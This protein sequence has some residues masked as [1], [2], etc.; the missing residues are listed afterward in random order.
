MG[1]LIGLVAVFA[2]FS[3]FG[4]ADFMSAGGAASWLNVASE[5]GI[6]A[7]PIG[8]LMIAGHLDL[9]G[10]QVHHRRGQH[11]HAEEA[12][13]VAGAQ[14]GD[15]QALLGFGGGRLLHY[16]GDFVKALA[17]GDEMAAYGAVEGE[18]A[19]MRG[20]DGGDGA[21]LGSG[22]FHQLLRGALLRAADVEMIAD[23]QEE[24]SG[25]GKGAGAKDR[26]AIAAGGGLLDELQ[27]A[28]LGAGGGPIGRL[29]PGTD[30][31]ANL[32]DTGGDDLVD[33]NL[34]GGLGK[35][36]AVDEGLKGK[37]ALGLASRSDDGSFDL[38]GFKGFRCSELRA[39]AGRIPVHSQSRCA[40]RHARWAA[41]RPLDGASGA[42]PEAA[43]Q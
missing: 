43:R 23:K 17:S 42:T 9:S 15:N 5:L 18:L 3:V 37:R 22:D 7:L 33:Q 30:H 16:L 34:E 32:L 27:A 39:E 25:T 2:F 1:S 28:G 19:F 11:V 14:A 12:K 8:L 31:D 36:V 4:G 40:P 20:L 41:R 29:I 24:G 10:Q 38:H 13:I 6:I 35:S 26:V 21:I